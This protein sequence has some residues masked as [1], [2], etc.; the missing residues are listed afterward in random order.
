M[1]GQSK[2]CFSGSH[3]RFNPLYRGVLIVT[4]YLRAA[5]GNASRSF[6]PLY[7]G[8]LI[9][10]S[11]VISTEEQAGVS[12]NP[13]YR[14]CSD[15]DSFDSVHDGWGEGC[16]NPLYRGVLIVTDPPVGLRDKIM[17]MFQSSL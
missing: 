4:L 9:V 12:F 6:N 8:V 10:T 1:T 2:S 11:R 3:V 15:C 7:R 16:F 5:L 17:S 13:L 14:R